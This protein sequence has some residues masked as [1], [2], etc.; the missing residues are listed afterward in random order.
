MKLA[1]KLVVLLSG[2]S[3]AYLA[4]LLTIQ[5]ASLIALWPMTETGGSVAED[6]STERNDGAYTGVTLNNSTFKNGRP[7]GLWDGT[8]DFNNV[9]SAGFDADFDGDDFTIAIWAKVSSAAVWTD[10][11]SRH[12]MFIKTDVAGNRAYVNKRTGNNALEVARFGNSVNK[13]AVLTG[14]STTDWFHFAITYDGT[15]DE[16]KFWID[17]VQVGGTKTLNGAW[18]GALSATEVTIGANSTIP[19]SVWDGFLAYAAIWKVALTPAEVLEVAT[20]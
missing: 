17:A 15:A 8:N 12:M 10:G 4:K 19:G 14:Q 20:V 11:A 9:Y 16:L 18:A 3:D 2:T 6:K 13:S 5:P 1:K 7:V